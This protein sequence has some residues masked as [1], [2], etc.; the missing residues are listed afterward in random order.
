MKAKIL[1]ILILPAVLASCRKEVGRYDLTEAQ[2]QIIPYEK[3]QVIS[4][5]NSEGKTDNVTVTENKLYWDEEII[6][7]GGFIDNCVMFFKTKKVTLKSEEGNL[8]IYLKLI[9]NGKDVSPGYVNCSFLIDIRPIGYFDLSNAFDTEGNFLIG[10]IHDSLEINGKIYYNVIEKTQV[11]IQ[12]F[13]NKTYGILQI[14]R[15]G[16]N[17][18]TLK[19]EP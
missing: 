7:S 19:S 18:L 5:I 6:D 11:P 8:V 16:E 10:G 17:Y 13:Y 12:F 3:G 1:I 2:K 14:K 4:F 9:A 15:N